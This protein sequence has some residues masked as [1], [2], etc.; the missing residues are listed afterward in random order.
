MVAAAPHVLY[1]QVKV[2]INQF[3]HTRRASGVPKRYLLPAIV[4]REKKDTL[5]VVVDRTTFLLLKTFVEGWK[6][7]RASYTFL[8]L[9]HLFSPLL[10]IF[11]ETEAVKLSY[12]RPHSLPTAITTTHSFFQKGTSSMLCLRSSLLVRRYERCF[13]VVK[14]ILK[15]CIYQLLLNQL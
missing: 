9:R 3:S 7:T 10:E 1:T 5:A 13:V 6:V 12:Y 15:C 2:V 8:R 14:G 4:S 11:F